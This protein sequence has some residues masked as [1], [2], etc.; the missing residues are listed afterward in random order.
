MT[1]E[2]AKRR[3]SAV[4][5]DATWSSE[6]DRWEQGSV[7][8]GKR[9]GRWT[10]WHPSGAP[11]GHETYVLGRLHG[12]QVV[13][14]GSRGESPFDDT[15]DRRI[16]RGELHYPD[17]QRMRERLFTKSGGLIGSD[18]KPVPKR[19]KGVPAS[20]SY[21]AS[22]S[23]WVDGPM[24][25]QPDSPITGRQR[26]WFKTG[27]LLATQDYV[28]GRLHGRAVYHRHDDVSLGA[29]ISGPGNR[30]EAQYVKGECRETGSVPWHGLGTHV[31]RRV[32][33]P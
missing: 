1:N 17:G 18:G 29:P 32:T 13:Q 20:A 16:F 27:E 10:Y 26:V 33:A 7:A 4:P 23:L 8:K 30:I 25:E 21:V 9:T 14:R 28:R 2:R 5:E 11:L 6:E 22:S 3:P 19:P 31:P 12:L 24:H 15:F